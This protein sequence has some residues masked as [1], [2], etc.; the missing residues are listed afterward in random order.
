MLNENHRQRRPKRAEQRAAYEQATE[1]RAQ[2]KE[3]WVLK[4]K[5]PKKQKIVIY[6]AYIF[7]TWE[8]K[9]ECQTEKEYIIKC[10]Y[11]Y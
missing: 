1:A 9:F 7:E 3:T 11:I 10:I 4:E 6:I 5:E 8:K 2:Q